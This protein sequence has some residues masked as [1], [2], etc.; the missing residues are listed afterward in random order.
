MQM[1]LVTILTFFSF[2]GIHASAPSDDESHLRRTLQSTTCFTDLN[3]I[4]ALE[5]AILNVSIAR[6]YVLCPNT[7]F[8]L[9]AIAG[10]GTAS[11]GFGPIQPRSN[12]FYKCGES[13]S[14]SNNCTLHG[15]DYAVYA[16]LP[17]L[18]QHTNVVIQGL[19]ISSQ[20]LGGAVL[21]RPGDITFTDCI[22][23]VSD[24]KH[25]FEGFLR[26]ATTNAKHMSLSCL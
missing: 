18:E 9:G 12:A 17:L 1:R 26:T 6:T 11:G 8:A 16:I 22:I 15:G 2:Q 13:G 20:K 21:A 10:D 7:T 5:K 4:H 24:I 19:T 3:K 25:S 14:S 23:R